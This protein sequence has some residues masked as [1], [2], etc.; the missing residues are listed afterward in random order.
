MSD[1]IPIIDG[2]LRNANLA[3]EAV[4]YLSRPLTVI[5]DEIAV[6]AAQVIAQWISQDQPREFEEP[7]MGMVF[8]VL[9]IKAVRS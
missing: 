8:A 9:T 5:P 7:V 1:T 3:I 6:A 2:K 4:T